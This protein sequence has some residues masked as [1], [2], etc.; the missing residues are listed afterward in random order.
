M[1][2]AERGEEKLKDTRGDAC[3]AT[4]VITAAALSSSMRPRLHVSLRVEREGTE[5]VVG[6]G[7]ET[8][9]SGWDLVAGTRTQRTGRWV[10]YLSRSKT[11]RCRTHH[12]TARLRSPTVQQGRLLRCLHS[13]HPTNA[14]HPLR[15]LV[16]YAAQR[17]AAPVHRLQSLP[18]LHCLPA[19]CEPSPLGCRLRSWLRLSEGIR[20]SARFSGELFPRI[21]RVSI[22]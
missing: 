10:L 14:F 4:S 6:V 12:T 5:A 9:I 15:N 8:E 7:V 21:L 3:G 18:S 22:P 20:S 19:R 16:R 13:Y 11:H 1:R 17:E 2:E